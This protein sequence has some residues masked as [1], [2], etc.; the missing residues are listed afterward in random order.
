M[1]PGPEINYNPLQKKVN[2]KQLMDTRIEKGFGSLSDRT[3][4]GS[5][6]VGFGSPTRIVSTDDNGYVSHRAV[7]CV[8]QPQ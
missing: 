8:T 7:P 4:Q 2:V 3:V 6:A 1:V 5:D